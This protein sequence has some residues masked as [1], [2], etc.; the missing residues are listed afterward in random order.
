MLHSLIPDRMEV[1]P[2][3]GGQPETSSLV[4]L[5]RRRN[6]GPVSGSS[7]TARSWAAEAVPAIK[8]D[9]I[10]EALK[11][12]KNRK[13]C[14]LDGIPP[15]VVK[16]LHRHAPGVLTALFRRCMETRTVPL[17]W[18]QA[19]IIPILKGPDKNP[20]VPSSYRPISLL[21]CVGKL[22]ERVVATRIE[23]EL[24]ESSWLSQAQY[25]YMPF[26]SSETAVMA[27]LEAV[28]RSEKDYA[29]GIFLDISG[30]FDRM[31]WKYALKEAQTGQITPYLV[32]ILADYLQGR[33]AVLKGFNTLLKKAL[34][35][36]CPQG[37]VLGPLLWKLTINPLLKAA[38]PEG[39]RTFAY[40]DDVAVLITGNTRRE[41]E[42][43]AGE[44]TSIL[45]TWSNQASMTFSAAKTHQMMLKGFLK[46]APTI[47]LGGMFIQP[48][49]DVRYLGVVLDTTGDYRKHVDMVVKKAVQAFFG[50]ALV[51]RVEWGIPHAPAKHLY[52]ALIVP[53]VTY[54]AAVWA[55]RTAQVKIKEK[56]RRAQRP[57]LI[58]I[59]KS[60]R[61]APTEALLAIAGILPL[62]LEVQWRAVAFAVRHGTKVRW[63]GE[64]FASDSAVEINLDTPLKNRGVIT[65]RGPSRLVQASILG[66]ATDLGQTEIFARSRK[67]K[68]ALRKKIYEVALGDWQR[69]YAD[70]DGAIK[71]LI[72]NVIDQMGNEWFCPFRAL[73]CFATRHGPFACY[74][75][76][77][78]L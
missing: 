75:E 73:T 29:V 63:K 77:F 11:K 41:M 34:N 72:P 59:A 19:L 51:A 9:E 3:D 45:L 54:G 38:W 67:I 42:K 30:A 4:D 20:A 26:V 48:K 15:E 55:R 44:V 33:T 5:Y 6:P 61:T 43:L 23:R 37:S 36:G 17:S 32:E 65:K 76:R 46:R 13:A 2:G 39:I 64:V 78:S 53:I 7:D 56:I 8:D 1:R 52:K 47:Q 70:Y 58:G 27:L 18:K 68:N 31:N 12:V 62:E 16:C 22:F 21:S 50:I 14:G 71:A 74:E 69:S 60:Y 66:A 25:G 24:N 57:A 35:Q 49:T 40:A 28:K 10:S